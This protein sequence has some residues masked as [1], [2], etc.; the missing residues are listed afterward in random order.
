MKRLFLFLLIISNLFCYGQVDSAVVKRIFK[1]SITQIKGRNASGY[2]AAVGDS[3]IFLA[4]NAPLHGMYGK[5]GT[6][7][8]KFHC[9]GIESVVIRRKGATGRGFLYGAVI[10]LGSGAIPGLLSGNDPP[11]FISFT[12][13]QKAIIGGFA[14]AIAGTIIGGIIGSVAK[15]RFQIGGRRERFDKM[16]VNISG[17]MYGLK[18]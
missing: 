8:I 1:A 13:G 12:A 11:G 5:E 2:L 17:K 10:G 6:N 18:Q 4:D 14:G 16:R 15:K 3:T 9:S 7:L